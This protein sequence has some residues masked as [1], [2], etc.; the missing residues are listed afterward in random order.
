MGS[1]ML[2]GISYT[3][4]GADVEANPQDTPSDTL[5]TIGIDGVVYEIEGGGGGGSDVAVDPII[6]S[7]TKIADI[8]VDGDT[9]SLYAPERSLT[10]AEYMALSTA[11]KNNGTTYY[12]TDMDNGSVKIFAP[13]IYSKYERK[14]GVWVDE[15]PLYQRTFDMTSRIISD[16]AWT[17][18][19]LGTSGSGISIKFFEGYFGLQGYNPANMSYDYYRGSSEYFTSIITTNSDDISVRPNMNAGVSVIAGM[20]TIWYTKDTDIEG[21][22]SYNSLGVPTVRIDDTEQVIGTWF[23]ETLYQ[24]AFPITINL[25]GSSRA[26]YTVITAST[27]SSLSI[28][29]IVGNNYSYI[30]YDNGQ[31]Q[32]PIP[33]S[34][35]VGTTGGVIGFSSDKTE[36]IQL[37]IS[38]FTGQLTGH[39]V[40]QYTKST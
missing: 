34:S 26:W 38:G 10:Y 22:S 3:S 40:I 39:I 17:N 20:C 14:V 13:I 21:S 30:D 19:I 23:G 2:N 7:G 12:I 18:N 33:Y 8:T 31:G 32:L 11:E 35:I 37:C 5:S 24:K 4:S 29:K 16:N 27:L 28:A 1:I 25:S 9:S 6:T 15:K 36:G